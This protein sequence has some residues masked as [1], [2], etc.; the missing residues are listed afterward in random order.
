MKTSL[1]KP[2]YTSDQITMKI[3]MPK[4]EH[5]KMIEYMKWAGFESD[6][7]F[8]QQAIR[9]VLDSDKTFKKHVQLD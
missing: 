8:I 6:S 1:I 5:T 2:T 9:F 3:K 7:D 4:P